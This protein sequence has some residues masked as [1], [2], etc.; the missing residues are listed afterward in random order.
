M[1]KGKLMAYFKERDPYTIGWN[2]TF[3]AKSL[4]LQNHSSEVTVQLC[5]HFPLTKC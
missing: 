1:Q 4:S 2:M 5:G 3:V